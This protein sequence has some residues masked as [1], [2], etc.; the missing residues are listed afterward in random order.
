MKI[1]Y[2][3]AD[4]ASLHGLY[5]MLPGILFIKMISPV[6][7]I[8]LLVLGCDEPT[9]PP[10]EDQMYFLKGT[11]VDSETGLPIPNATV[12]IRNP[13]SPDSAVFA[14]DS[15]TYIAGTILEITQT[16]DT[17]EFQFEF[18]LI[19]RDTSLIHQLF[20]FNSGFCLWRYDQ[21]PVT[22]TAVNNSTDEL[23][24]LLAPQEDPVQEEPVR[25]FLPLSIGNRWTYSF[26]NYD[27]S[28]GGITIE[29]IEGTS[30]WESISFTAV[31]EDTSY[32][33]EQT[34]NGT[35]IYSYN[36][37]WTSFTD[38]SYFVDR[39]YH[40]VIVDSSNNKISILDTSRSPLSYISVW[41]LQR[42]GDPTMMSDTLTY[43]SRANS[44]LILVDGIGIL[45][46]GQR[47]LGNSARV[48]RASLQ[49]WTINGVTGTP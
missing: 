15:L 41:T 31:N 19:D 43:G 17:G 14:G 9:S 37:W 1:L 22:V 49:Q 34:V 39:K 8:I 35:R 33:I 21:S 7:L 45:E 48:Y 18:F 6:L 4:T 26:R 12:G 32:V 30:V 24:I 47:W 25:D 42:Y 20:A 11:V 23:T 27:Y 16:S 13:S 46:F 28:A 10:L 3:Q 2:L 29:T 5:Q 40:F 38:T 44:Y 36:Q